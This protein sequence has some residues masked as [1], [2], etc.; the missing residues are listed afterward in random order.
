MLGEDLTIGGVVRWAPVAG[1]EAIQL[2]L[3]SKLEGVEQQREVLSAACR[4][5]ARCVPPAEE[6]GRHTELVIGYVQSGK[7]LSFTTVIALAR[8]NGLRLVVVLSGSTKELANQSR[9]RLLKDLAIHGERLAPWHHIHNPRIDRIGE[10]RSVLDEWKGDGGT[11]GERRTLLITLLKN[12]VNLSHLTKLL[13]ALG[14]EK[15]VPAL[16]I[17]DEADQASLNNLV[18]E[19][20][21]STTYRRIMTLRDALPQHSYLEY[22]ATP[23]GPL[24]ISLFDLLSPQSVSLLSPGD[25]YVGSVVFFAPDTPYVKVIPD[26][27]IPAR[28][29]VDVDPPESLKEA[30]RL[31][32][33]G[34]ASGFVRR[35][36][37]RHK[38][39]MMI[40]PSQYVASHKVFGAWVRSV[41]GY[42]AAVLAGEVGDDDRNELIAE[43]STTRESLASTVGGLEDAGTLIDSLLDAIRRT[44]IR[45]VNSEA[46][47]RGIDWKRAYSWILVGGQVLDRGFTVEGLTVTYMP[48]GRGVGNADT[49]QQR[50][51]FLGYKRKYL[52]YCRVFLERQARTAYV[53]YSRHE[54]AMRNSLAAFAR[55][56]RPLAAFRR[57]FI[58]DPALE[59]TRKAVYEI[60]YYRVRL[61]GNW[62]APSRADPSS[63]Y[64][65]ANRD[66]VDRFV[67]DNKAAFKDMQGHPDRTDPQRHT[68]LSGLSL[69]VVLE[70]LLVDYRAYSEADEERWLVVLAGIGRF[71][72]QHPGATASV[73]LMSSGRER[74]RSIDPKTL[75]ITNLFQGAYPVEVKQR[76]SIYPGDVKIATEDDITIQVHIVT[77]HKGTTTGGEPFEKKAP[78]LALHFSDPFVEDLVVQPQGGQAP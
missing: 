16:I 76:G 34:V 37:E 21:Q 39:S 58:L 14:E 7:T 66:L 69:R 28:N 65:Q 63:P 51:R 1:E 27:Q 26:N 29:A 24:L 62:Y 36:F 38:R 70:Q 8:D 3:R 50:A 13:T 46:E 4:V 25:D 45:V 32:L 54:E 43:F 17:D 2:L 52:G 74:K 60:D 23:Q 35:D 20:R 78:M 12:H 33:L 18:R 9:D 56:G 67:H 49:L 77:L 59:P 44:E 11:R 72:S 22:T 42:W 30:L 47:V 64:Y 19:G 57:V 41:L 68:V 75:E 48:R 53:D 15:H 40:H 5:L 6:E 55:S 31:F 71:V 10:V 73:I 61:R